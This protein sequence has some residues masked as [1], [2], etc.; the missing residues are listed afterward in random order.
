MLC[1]KCEQDV[2]TVICGSCGKTVRALGPFCYLCGRSLEKKTGSDDDADAGEI[3][4]STRT[5]CSDG[6]CIGV[7]NEHGVC[8]V[9]GKPYTQE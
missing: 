4:F 1:E 2:D 3:D 9:C 8:R 7:I 5:L 6:T